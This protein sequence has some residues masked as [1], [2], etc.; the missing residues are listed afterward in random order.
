MYLCREMTDLSLPRIG[1][2]FGGR[3]H[4]TVIHA[5]DKITRAMQVDMQVRNIINELKR[6]IT[7][8]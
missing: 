1:E 6:Q 3:D 4:T 2:A 5:C 8:G 7:E